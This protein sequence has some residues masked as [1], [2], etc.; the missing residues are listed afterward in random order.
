[1]PLS[2]EV[3]VKLILLLKAQGSK[4]GSNLN[5][6]SVRARCRGAVAAMG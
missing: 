4:P 2:F 1:M 3:L 6:V 5:L